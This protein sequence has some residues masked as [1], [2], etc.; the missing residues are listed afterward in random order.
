MRLA[1]LGALAVVSACAADP[2]GPPSGFRVDVIAL[3]MRA[4][5]PAPPRIAV[6]GDRVVA[7]AD[8]SISD[9]FAYG[10]VAG[11]RHDALVVTLTETAR[12]QVCR[13]TPFR[14]TV[15][16]ETH[17]VPRGARLVVVEQR[18]SR[19]PGTPDR[20]RELGRAVVTVD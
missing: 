16:V 1:A 13:G 5:D 20:T 9:C 15:T 10:A 8:L 17:G 2:V 3:P 7:D 6:R 12:D 19:E 11:L 18:T 14:N 4:P